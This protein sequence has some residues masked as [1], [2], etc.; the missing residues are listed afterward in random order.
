MYV[1]IAVL[2]IQQFAL[3]IEG[4]VDDVVLVVDN[5]KEIIVY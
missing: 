4:Y 1:D 2:D 5:L 3:V